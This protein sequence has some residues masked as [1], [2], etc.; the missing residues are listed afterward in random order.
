MEDERCIF[1]AQQADERLGIC[2]LGLAEA[3]GN[4]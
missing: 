2:A 3:G 1:A 4:G